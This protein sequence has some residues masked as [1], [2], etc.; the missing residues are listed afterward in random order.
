MNY[1]DPVILDQLDPMLVA[2]FLAYLTHRSGIDKTL[3][4]LI[5]AGVA[6]QLSSSAWSKVLREIHVYEHDFRELQYLQ[7]VQKDIKWKKV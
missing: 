2:E 6:H 4:T 3:M 7:A 1:Y 5:C